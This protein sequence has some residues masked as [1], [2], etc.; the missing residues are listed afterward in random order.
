MDRQDQHEYKASLRVFSES[1][2]LADLV[3]ALGEPTG[4][5]DIGDPVSVRLPDGSRRT[6]AYWSLSSSAQRTQP[7]DDHV[8]ELVEFIEA[9]SRQFDALKDN[10]EIDIFCGV[11]TGDGTQGG[12]TLASDLIRKL[13]ALNLDVSF[14]LY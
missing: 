11:F 13:A 14:D 5:Y 6:R 7:L 8:A 10:A 2:A 1:L 12:F 9:H 4:S 3:A